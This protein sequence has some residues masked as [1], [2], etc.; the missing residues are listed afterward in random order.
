M[1]KKKMT[2]EELTHQLKQAHGAGLRSIVLYGSAATN[3]NVEGHSDTNVLVIVESIE[4]ETLRKLG[5]TT[6]AWQEAGNAPPLTLTV[7]EW[8]R[9][10]DIFPMEYADVLERHKLLFGELPLT[11]IKVS[12]SDLRLQ[13][14]HEAMGTLLRLRRGVMSAGM[15]PARQRELLQASFSALM[16][17]FRGV[18]RLHGR[19]PSRDAT[20]VIEE[21]ASLCNFES[22]PFERVAQHTR[23][24]TI[25]ERDTE[26]VL[27]A[28]VRGM[29]ALVEYL[30]RYDPSAASPQSL[31]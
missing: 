11:G 19:S 30:D 7:D 22:D 15:D 3:E 13:V 23:G 16:V 6:R 2:V 24:D 4:L 31:A 12:Q 29:N 27:G 14:E 25:A 10:A 8:K 1:A 18:V 9:S 28:Y 5:A 26:A 17:V 21:V 20:S